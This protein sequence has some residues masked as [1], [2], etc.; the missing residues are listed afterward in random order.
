[1]IGPKSLVWSNVGEM[2]NCQGMI[3]L[4]YYRNFPQTRGVEGHRGLLFDELI[5]TKLPSWI[6]RDLRII[7]PDSRVLLSKQWPQHQLRSYRQM[8]INLSYWLKILCFGQ[9][10]FDQNQME[11]INSL[12]LHPNQPPDR[13]H[14]SKFIIAFTSK[15]GFWTFYKKSCSV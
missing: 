9:F 12:F 13:K 3:S 14:L 8:D 10:D 11:I 6:K 7:T 2:P 1:M 4:M 5:K 15:C